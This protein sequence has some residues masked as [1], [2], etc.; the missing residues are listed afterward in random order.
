VNNYQDHSHRPGPRGFAFTLTP[1]FRTKGESA[2]GGRAGSGGGTQQTGPDRGPGAPFGTGRSR[3]SSPRSSAAF[4]E[5]PEILDEPTSSALSS[6]DRFAYLSQM[7][8]IPR[9]R[10]S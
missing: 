1:T 7:G 6:R 2:D 3:P 8:N 9:S 5:R 4:D 10:V